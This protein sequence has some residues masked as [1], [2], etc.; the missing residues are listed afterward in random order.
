MSVKKELIYKQARCWVL[1]AQGLTLTAACEAVAGEFRSWFGTD[2]D[3]LDYLDRLRWPEGFGRPGCG[4]AGSRWV[5][6]G[7]YNCPGC[8]E[9]TLVTAP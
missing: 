6:D 7:R 9:R 1:M 3:C 4:H 5:A 2:E 8:G